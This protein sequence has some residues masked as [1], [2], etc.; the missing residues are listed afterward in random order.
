TVEPDARAI[1]D[2]VEVEPD[3]A[4]ALARGQLKLCAIPP[5]NFERAVVRHRQLREDFA[6]R[7]IRA[8]QLAHV[9]AEVWIGIDLIVHKRRHDQARKNN[10]PTASR[11]KPKAMIRQSVVA[12]IK[13]QPTSATRLG[14]G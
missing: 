2:A 4:L 7:V 14:S 6:D 8:R 5:S 10:K 13:I 1:V 3:G 11:P 9:H 12:K